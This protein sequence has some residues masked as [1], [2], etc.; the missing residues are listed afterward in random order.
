MN[1]FLQKFLTFSPLLVLGLVIALGLSGCG[2]WQETVGGGIKDYGHAKSYN[3]EVIPVLY[4]YRTRGSPDC[5]REPQKGQESRLVSEPSKKRS[6]KGKDSNQDQSA[7][8]Q[9]DIPETNGQSGA[10]DQTKGVSEPVMKSAEVAPVTIDE[11]NCT[12]G[13]KVIF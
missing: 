11:P 5:Y 6:P 9:V 8:M 1:R 10:S 13:C 4:C 2:W 12:C 3:P 7:E